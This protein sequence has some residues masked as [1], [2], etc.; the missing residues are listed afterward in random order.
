M[1]IYRTTSLFSLVVMTAISALP[2]SPTSVKV[3]DLFG[4][5]EKWNGTLIRATGDIETGQEGGPWLSGKGCSSRIEVKCGW[6]A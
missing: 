5:L 2:Q 3:C 6:Q 4:D 1:M